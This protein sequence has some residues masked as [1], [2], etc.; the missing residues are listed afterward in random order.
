[1][2]RKKRKGPSISG[3]FRKLFEERP[4]LLAEKSNDAILTRYRKDHSVPESE[5]LPISVRNNLANIKSVL[6]RDGR[7]ATGTSSVKVESRG[8]SAKLEGLEEFIDEALTMAKTLD[9]ENLQSVI[10]HLRKARNEVVWKMGQ[11]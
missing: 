9:R 1:M 6:R 3:Y 7:K 5:V 11:S 8:G 4:E 2:G 10:G